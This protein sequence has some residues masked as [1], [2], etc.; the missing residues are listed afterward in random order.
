MLKNSRSSFPDAKLNFAENLLDVET[1]N[2]RSSLAL[3]LLKRNL[4]YKELYELVP[5]KTSN[6]QNR[7]Q[8]G[9]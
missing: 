5:T 1:I 6:D 4:S 3:K 8:T 7:G 2:Q 9:R